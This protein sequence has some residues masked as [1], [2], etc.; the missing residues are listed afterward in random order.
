LLTIG[1]ACSQKDIGDS[2]LG[3]KT[4]TASLHSLRRELEQIR[5]HFPGDMSIY[6]KNLVDCGGNRSRFGQSVRNLQRYQAANCRRTHAP[7]GVGKLSLS[8]RIITR[9]ADERLPS[10]VLYALEPGLSPTIKDLLTLMI[11]TSDNE[12]TDL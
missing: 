3:S 5:N 11:I 1:T 10:G 12:A 9:A 7:G 2:D 4:D 6:M 8:D